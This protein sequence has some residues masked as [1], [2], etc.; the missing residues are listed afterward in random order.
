MQAPVVANAAVFDLQFSGPFKSTAD[1][2]KESS[3][4]ESDAE[5]LTGGCQLTAC[6]S[7]D[8]L[9]GPACGSAPLTVGPKCSQFGLTMFDAHS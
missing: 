9:Y 3:N 7:G 5:L 1:A 6:Y 8:T 4:F 2:L